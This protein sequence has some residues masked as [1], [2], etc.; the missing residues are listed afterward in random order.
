[1]WQPVWNDDRVAFGDVMLLAAFNLAPAK[2]V[3]RNLFGVNR[4]SA[5]HERRR[6]LHD[7]NDV[8]IERVNFRLA[9]FE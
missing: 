9:G 5:C 6:S 7:I 1:M 8:G 3:G 4:F 2:F